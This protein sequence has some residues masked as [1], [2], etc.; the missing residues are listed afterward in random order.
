MIVGLVVLGVLVL[1]VVT[2]I[3]GA[4][5]GWRQ[6]GVADDVVIEKARGEAYLEAQRH[7]HGGQFGSH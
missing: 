7:Q 6:V 3:V 5:R 1:I 2:S 4:R